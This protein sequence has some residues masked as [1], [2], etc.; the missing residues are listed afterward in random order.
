MTRM[1]RSRAASRRRAGRFGG[2]SGPCVRARAEGTSV[3]T[4]RGVAA[5]SE[6]STR[7]ATVLVLGLCFSLLGGCVVTNKIE[8]DVPTNTPPAIVVTGLA[9]TPPGA[10]IDR[11]IRVDRSDPTQPP[12]TLTFNVRDPD[13]S[14]SLEGRIFVDWDHD[15]GT[16]P[17]PAL[18]TIPPSGTDV[19]SASQVVPD[20]LLRGVGE[21]HRIEL[22]VAGS[23]GPPDGRAPV[24][25]G[26]IAQ[27]VFWAEVIDDTHPSAD[28]STCPN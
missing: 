21:C 26:D 4:D 23:F 16:G 19:R 13:V 3:A 8:F 11:I 17:A 1:S 22:L 24:E 9:G 25:T 28:L 6:A 18:F 7:G 20:N 2:N 14:Q 15:T 12:V 10:S 27:A 5:K